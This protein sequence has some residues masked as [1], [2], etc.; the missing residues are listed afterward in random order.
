MMPEF[1]LQISGWL[2]ALIFPTATLVQLLTILKNKSAKGVS[3]I[4][5]F[6]FGIGNIGVYIYTEKY[7]NLESILGFLGTALIDFIIVFLVLIRY[8]FNRSSD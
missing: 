6:L 1:I 2:P 4:T 5:W 7:T 3:A 8:G